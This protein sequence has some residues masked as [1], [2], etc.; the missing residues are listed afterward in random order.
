[1]PFFEYFELAFRYF[2]Q[3]RKEY[4]AIQ[5][6]LTVI[7]PVSNM[8]GHLKSFTDFLDAGINVGFRFIVVHD[9]RDELTGPELEEI[10]SRYS[11]T[12][13]TL[14][15]VS[16]G[17]PGETRNYGIQHVE[18]D[19]VCF[20]DSDDEPMVENFREMIETAERNQKNIAIG[21][22]E[23]LN[24]TKT[25]FLSHKFPSQG[26]DEVAKN[27][28]IWR[29]A[30]RLD[31]VGSIRFPAL[32]MGEDSIFLARLF[33]HEN[34]IFYFGKVVYRYIQW[35]ENQLTRNTAAIQE[36]KLSISILKTTVVSQSVQGNSFAK[37]ILR[38]QI[39]SGIKS[40]KSSLKLLA[41]CSLVYT[42]SNLPQKS[43]N[44]NDSAKY[45]LNKN[46][47]V[48]TSGGLGNQLFQ[49]SAGQYFSNGTGFNLDFGL[50]AGDTSV[51]EEY[52]LPE[53]V[54]LFG[55]S[56]V[57]RFFR[58]V[59]NIGLR[60]GRF[61]NNGIPKILLTKIIAAILAG[62]LKREVR[63]QNDTN[64]FFLRNGFESESYLIGY[65]QDAR[66]AS[67]ARA[68]IESILLT[69][70]SAFFQSELQEIMKDK[71]LII[72]VRLGDYSSEEKFGIPSAEYFSKAIDFLNS[73]DESRKIWIFSNQPDIAVTLLPDLSTK[74]F[75]IVK[76]DQ[77]S[78]GETLELMKYGSD[79]IISNS[80]FSWWGAFLRKDQSARVIAPQP[81]FKALPSSEHLCPDDWVRIPI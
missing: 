67:Y 19:W 42:F 76:S 26:L 57:P 56:T 64:K 9:K 50:S 25:N 52:L 32:W 48:S 46:I 63:I 8:A 61:N 78:T 18:T 5:T 17:N 6:M 15:E 62:Y 16:F 21:C 14:H 35:S 27:P 74:K 22:F 65:F 33:L 51:L 49:I 3:P 1:L 73:G 4:E 2:R 36:L 81:W 30:F 47:T 10:V 44:R 38:R 39:Y 54:T 40:G 23:S 59:H 60:L 45:L 79:Y 29:W 34:E 12:R 80:T 24:K 13:V 7:V 55:S 20:W 37:K 31:R 72:H 41:L 43:R 28:G 77:L 71:P 53:G 66:Y 68:Y 75:K 58:L 69:S 70:P 11:N